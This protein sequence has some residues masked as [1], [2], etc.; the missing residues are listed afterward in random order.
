MASEKTDYPPSFRGLYDIVTRLR[1]PGGC[2][3]DR[4]QTP[5]SL[6]SAL[7]EEVFECI[8][9]IEK[10]DPSHVREELGD[11]LLLVSMIARI[12]EER[13]DFSQ[14]DVFSEIEEKLIRRHPHVFG[15]KTI[16]DPDEVVKQ[17]E[18]IKRDVEGRDREDSLLAGVP[19]NIP[20]LERSYHL[21]KKA[22][23]KGFDW[24]EAH[25]VVEKLHEEIGE[26]AELMEAPEPPQDALEEELGDILFSV[27][28]LC[29]FMNFD[30]T[31]ALHKANKKF[32][33]RFGHV[34]RRMKEENREI[35]SQEF[36]RMD[37]L[38][39]EAKKQE[40]R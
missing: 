6:K 13:G 28:N 16:A 39:D 34:E 22:A 9:A 36:D 19:K 14:E 2:P 30:P 5:D 29:R 1:A 10:N 24:Q 32:V 26:L 15:E 25:Q 33:R 35:S 27:V 23:K 31:L 4:K 11:V 8:D 18:A 40:R 3:W 20:P 17:W 37:A 12:Y 21:Q 7:I 38:W